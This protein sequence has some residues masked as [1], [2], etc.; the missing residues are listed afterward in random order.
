MQTLSTITFVM[1]AILESI[2]SKYPEITTQYS[3]DLSY[4]YSEQESRSNSQMNS[5]ETNT[6]LPLLVWNRSNL[7]PTILGGRGTRFSA[8]EE[9]TTKKSDVLHYRTAH[10]EFDFRFSLVDKDVATVESFEIDYLS[11]EGLGRITEVDVD[12]SS[13]DLGTLRYYIEWDKS[14]SNFITNTDTNSYSSVDGIARVWGYFVSLIGESP[15]I[16]DV[17]LKLEERYNNSLIESV[18][19]YN[20]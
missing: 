20:P 8:Y 17:K 2:R 4:V 13:A 10:L 16:T 9:N 11:K 14:L 15:V 18:Q 12:F 3:Q 5:Q 6:S 1:K 7:R 19:T